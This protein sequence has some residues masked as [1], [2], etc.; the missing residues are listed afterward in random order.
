MEYDLP[1]FKIIDFRLSSNPLSFECV[2]TGKKKLSEKSSVL[3]Y[4]LNLTKFKSGMQERFLLSSLN[5]EKYSAA[6]TAG[7][8]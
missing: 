7:V 3:T 5:Y 6:I 2:E 8:L 1:I 4:N